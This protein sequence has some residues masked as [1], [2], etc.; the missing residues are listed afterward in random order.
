[1]NRVNIIGVRINWPSD[2]KGPAIEGGED[3]GENMRELQVLECTHSDDGSG[4][5]RESDVLERTRALLP[6]HDRSR[7]FV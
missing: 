1:M 4:R 7:T 3:D 2:T 5:P 6:T